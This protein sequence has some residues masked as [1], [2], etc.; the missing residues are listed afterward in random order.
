MTSTALQV[1]DQPNVVDVSIASDG[2]TVDTPYGPV[3]LIAVGRALGGERVYLTRAEHHYVA[4][5]V[6]A[7]LAVYP[8]NRWKNR[9]QPS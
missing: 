2:L 6:R 7:G 8:S 5:R 3:D 4:A 9:R 1:S